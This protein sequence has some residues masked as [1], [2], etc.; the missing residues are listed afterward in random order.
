MVT[1]P[2]G[3]ELEPRP[4]PPPDD[5]FSL[6]NLLTYARFGL[7]VVLFVL[8]GVESWLGCLVV[9]ALAALTDLL[10]GHLAR[11]LNLAS[12]LGRNLDPLADKVLVCGAFIFLLPRGIEGHWLVPWM[13]V[14]VVLREL[15]ITT[16][17]SLLEGHGIKFGADWLGKLK[18]WLQSAALVAIF[19]V[20]LRGAPET[21]DWLTLARDGL[22]YA[23]VL[24]TA[25]SG[26]QYFW[27]AAVLRPS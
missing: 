2:P 10:D 23:M 15:L 7:A 1:T 25:L 5:F 4:A 18:M 3:K 13:V 26:L 24:A 6:P 17:R 14:V 27:K 20:Q 22:I 21:T 11:R 9:F 19:V 12:A 8:I 16:L